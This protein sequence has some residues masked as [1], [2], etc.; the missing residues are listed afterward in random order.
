[1]FT[2]GH[3]PAEPPAEDGLWD[4]SGQEPQRQT[5]ETQFTPQHLRNNLGLKIM[6]ILSATREG[7]KMTFDAKTFVTIFVLHEYGY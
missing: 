6:V 4:I 1:M 7:F 2:S 5:V 3:H